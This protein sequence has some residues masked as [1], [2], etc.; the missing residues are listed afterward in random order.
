MKKSNIFLMFL[1]AML[2]TLSFAACAYNGVTDSTPPT[3]NEQEGSFKLSHTQLDLDLY[4]DFTLATVHAEGEVSFSSSDASVVTVSNDG[5]VIA[6]KVG[7]ATITATSGDEVA[8]CKVQV[9]DNGIVPVMHLEHSSIQVLIGDVH[10]NQASLTFEGSAC[11]GV[12]FTYTSSDETIATVTNDGVVTAN[13]VGNCTI[14]VCAEYRGVPS[15]LLT[16]TFSVNVVEDVAL[17][18]T[19]A[20]AFEVYSAATVRGETFQ[21]N[22]QATYSFM[23]NGQEYQGN[24]VYSWEVQDSAI[25]TVNENGLITGVSAGETKVRVCYSGEDYNLESEWMT[26]V[27]RKPVVEVEHE[28]LIDAFDKQLKG[29]TA[30]LFGDDAIQ[31]I[32][33]VFNGQTRIEYPVIN[34]VV[35]GETYYD[36]SDSDGNPIEKERYIVGGD[37]I[38]E[39]HTQSYALKMKGVVATK[40]I[41]T[42]TELFK[43]HEY[44]KTT[45]LGTYE[46][47]IVLGADIQVQSSDYDVQYET[48]KKYNN[49]EFFSCWYDLELAE[50]N[51]YANGGSQVVFSG[52]AGRQWLYAN[53]QL[54]YNGRYAEGFK[55]TLDGR[56]HT[57][58]NINFFGSGLFVR[59][60]PSGVVKN[61][62]FDEVSLVENGYAI[63]NYNLGL[64][65]NVFISIKN[66]A[67]A[68]K[69]GTA[70]CATLE[71][72]GTI[73]NCVVYHDG[74][75]DSSND[76]FRNAVFNE[77]NGGTVENVIVITDEKRV[78]INGMYKYEDFDSLVADSLDYGNFNGCWNLDD[79]KLPVFNGYNGQI[80]PEKALQANVSATRV[81]AG[82]TIIVTSNY[83]TAT[84]QLKESY[85]FADKITIDGMTVSIADDIANSIDS[86][87]TFILEVCVP[88]IETAYELTIVIK[89]V[90]TVNLATNF[91]ELEQLTETTTLLDSQITG[92][93][94]SVKVDGVQ[95]VDYVV[96]ADRKLTIPANALKSVKYGDVTIAMETEDVIYMQPATLVTKVLK[97]K[98]D[99]VNIH[100]F[101][102][103]DEKG[104][105]DG[106]LVLGNDINMYG[107]K[108]I[109]PSGLESLFESYTGLCPRSDADFTTDTCKDAAGF[110][111]I[112]DGRGHS[113]KNLNIFNQGIFYRN[114]GTIKNIAIVATLQREYTA[115]IAYYNDGIIDN[116]FVQAVAS[117]YI[118]N[119]QHGCYGIT[120]K[121]SGTISNS[122]VWFRNDWAKAAAV[123]YEVGENAVFSNVVAY[124]T[125]STTHAG[126]TVYKTKDDIPADV[127]YSGFDARY[128][129][130]TSYVL[131]VFINNPFNLPVTKQ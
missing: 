31:K 111:G 116:V 89:V 46:G 77:C 68:G 71:S 81:N 74:I 62:A 127:V 110:I 104:V 41:T 19:N 93:I 117:S 53:G 94:I 34:G 79:Y 88:G 29:D 60:A 130:M 118:N 35:H 84:L 47:Y 5:K 7:E 13:K 128:W 43:L 91:G 21:T 90:R 75:A 63:C 70:I 50:C 109:V 4:G 114:S 2:M 103:T 18:I 27:V 51:F 124:T 64:I 26:V 42:A 105:Y 61:I 59:I 15:T 33:E 83:S 72:T 78:S 40:V 28:A 87:A 12:V 24:G 82:D 32:V 95:V 97:T 1:M 9:V 44:T 37:K 106:Y 36:G 49:G 45:R 85:A 52:D 54:A 30:A 99:F 101:V 80:I 102:K 86:N 76:T 131:P 73:S 25:A 65:D 48:I 3:S 129:D 39:I 108:Y 121:N 55:G 119:G 96:S 123:A 125:A 8:T 17:T 115:T 6:L 20:E 113:I 10:E 69:K 58:S 112:L 126:I 14:T 122:V 16:K 56:G 11:E 98:E 38:I 67:P 100:S 92:D 23:R 120:R 22:I 66:S 107:A 57:I